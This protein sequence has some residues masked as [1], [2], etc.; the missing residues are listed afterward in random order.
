[1]FD[2]LDMLKILPIATGLEMGTYALI[3]SLLAGGASIAA[4]TVNKPKKQDVARPKAPALPTPPD[5]KG[6]RKKTT[7][8]IR[9]GA[10]SDQTIATSARGVL[11]KAPVSRKTLLGE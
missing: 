10:I 11:T 5:E 1:M 3:A 2:L 6:I 7:K 4:A 9:R 8:K